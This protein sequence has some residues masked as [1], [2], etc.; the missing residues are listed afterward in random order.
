MNIIPLD[1]NKKLEANQD[2]HKAFFFHYH[3]GDSAQ[4]AEV[5]ERWKSSYL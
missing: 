4:F 1:L 2:R 5:T 3:T